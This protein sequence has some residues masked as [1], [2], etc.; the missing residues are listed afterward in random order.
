M[1]QE[2]KRSYKHRVSGYHCRS[3]WIA[4]VRA[5]WYQL[6]HNHRVQLKPG[7]IISANQDAGNVGN[8]PHCF[9]LETA[10]DGMDCDGLVGVRAQS[11]LYFLRLL[12]N[13]D[14]N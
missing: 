6:C 8:A 3:A 11:S 1:A 10:N 2:Q 13:A 7:F 5:S 9:G 14:L 12:K 4:R